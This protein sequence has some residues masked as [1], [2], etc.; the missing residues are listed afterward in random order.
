MQSFL[1][2]YSKF[3]KKILRGKCEYNSCIDKTAKI[4]SGCSL[5]NSSIGRYSYL[6]YDCEIINTEIGSF[7]SLASGIHIGLA[8]HPIEW[9]STSPVFQDVSNSSLK[10][11]FANLSAPVSK[12]TIIEHDVWIG[13]NVIVKAGVK[14]GTGAVIASGA[15]VTKDI[16]PYA[17]VGGVPAKIIRFRFDEAT[18]DALLNT[19][20][21]DLPEEELKR[22]APNINKP[23]DFIRQIKSRNL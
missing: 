20:W 10:G 16:P 15:V 17:I 5:F 23:E 11:K 4:N 19:K 8:E 9:V 1:Y 7:C 2:Y 3:V 12:K 22:F 6:G 13:T 18:V 21:W 14:I